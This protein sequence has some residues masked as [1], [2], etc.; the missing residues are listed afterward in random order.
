VRIQIVRTELPRRDCGPGG[1]FRGYGNI[2]VGVRCK[3]RRDN[4]LDLHP[5]THQ[6]R[7]GCSITR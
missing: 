1:N 6:R 4:L 7:S 2:H 5:V 3:N